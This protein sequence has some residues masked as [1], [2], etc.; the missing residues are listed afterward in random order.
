MATTTNFGW[1]TP[2]DSANVKDGAAAIRSLGTAIDTS[3]LD[4]KG[5]TTGQTLTKA[6]NTDMD[7]TWATPATG[8]GYTVIASGNFPTNVTR[9]DLTGIPDTYVDLYLVM[10]NPFTTQNTQQFYIRP[11]NNTTSASYYLQ[12]QNSGSTTF[13]NSTSNAFDLGGFG[14]LVS[15]NNQRLSL[16]FKAY[17]Y[18]STNSQKICEFW[19]TN[20]SQMYFQRGI[21]NALSTTAISSLSIIIANNIN[22]QGGSYVLYGVK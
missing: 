4:L 22:F 15:S 9:V 14:I 12:T 2:D 17:N 8:G 18:K 6:T 7:F 21:A 5:G 11:N 16:I 13:T 3:L 19:G 20:T 1:A 10:E